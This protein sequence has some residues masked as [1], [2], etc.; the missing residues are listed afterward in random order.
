[1]TGV[2]VGQ[3]LPSCLGELRVLDIPRQA[4]PILAR[5]EREVEHELAEAI[6]GAR[7]AQLLDELEKFTSGRSWQGVSD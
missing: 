7:R 5:Q 4:I 2:P 6:L 1:M 3:V